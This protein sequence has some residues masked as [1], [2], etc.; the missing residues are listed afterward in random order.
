M[1]PRAAALRP[2]RSRPRDHA[3]RRQ[4]LHPP[5]GIT[6]PSSW[7]TPL[8][9]L[10]SSRLPRRRLACRSTPAGARRPAVRKL[11]ALPS[12]SYLP[13]ASHSVAQRAT[14]RAARGDA[15]PGAPS[16]TCSSCASAGASRRRGP[17]DRTSASPA[18]R[19]ADLSRTTAAARAPP[20]RPRLPRPS[21]LAHGPLLHPGAG[22]E[23]EHPLDAREFPGRR[24]APGSG[25]ARRR[26]SCDYSASPSASAAA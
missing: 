25:A 6:S 18:P 19:N 22:P 14:I 16:S 4:L 9:L 24:S 13:P 5:L 20:P 26:P 3:A 12:S 11:P 10:G 8:S 7:S 21:S 17:A 2:S 23:L 1:D 15:D